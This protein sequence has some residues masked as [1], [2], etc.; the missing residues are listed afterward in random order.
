VLWLLPY[1]VSGFSAPFIFKNAPTPQMGGHFAG[2]LFIFAGGWSIYLARRF[3]MAPWVVIF[4]ACVLVLQ[5]LFW[6]WRF[7]NNLP[8]KEA[9]FMGLPG[10]T[11]HGLL[12]GL[13]LA[14][15]LT[16]VRSVIFYRERL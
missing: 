15:A 12:T 8:L 9:V 2:A 14:V 10:S 13:Y 4:F 7:S 11:W 6:G 5:A 3:Q 1:F 16:L